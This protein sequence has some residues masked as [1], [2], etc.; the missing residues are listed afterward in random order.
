MNRY[1]YI[2]V[3]AVLLALWS[4]KSRKVIVEEVVP[5]PAVED[6][7]KPT[8]SPSWRPPVGD[9]I[10]QEMRAV[11]L[12]TA[13]GLD[14]P[15]AKADTPNGI[16]R[17]KE[18]L[19]RILDRL[20]SDG[21]NTIFYQARLSGSTTYR[22]DREPFARIFTASGEAPDYDPLAYATEACHSR[23]LSIHAWLV[24]YPLSSSSKRPHPLLVRHKDWLISHKGGWHLD[25][26]KPEVRTYIASI[27]KDI[28]Q[29]YR[30]DGIHFDY[31][32]YP[33][34]A[35][36]FRDDAS[37]LRY[38]PQGL[39][40]SQW[41]RNNLTE[42]LREVN[43]VVRQI[44]PSI[45]IS[46]APLGKLSMIPNLGRPHGWTALESVHQD[47]ETWAE[48]HI[49]D[50]VAPMMYYKDL[51][52]EP[53]LIEWVQRVG[54]Y[55]PVVPG[56]APYRI[57]E[58]GWD[59]TVISNQIALAR[60]HRASGVSM[61]REKNIGPSVPRL[62]TL[63]QRAFRATVLPIEFKPYRTD[64]PRLSAPVLTDLKLDG[65]MLTLKW[66]AGT[67]KRPLSYRVWA[68]VTHADGRQEGLLL[69]EGL[70]HT[71]CTLRITEFPSE[72]CIEFGVEALDEWNRATPCVAPI[73]YNL[74]N[75]RLMGQ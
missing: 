67:G 73:E 58:D 21:Y 9:S 25:P 5:T 49:V 16:R 54:K 1:I 7:K 31:F 64:V 12:T 60:Q 62:R 41:R 75:Y 29:R 14:W 8:I 11:W 6:P 53:F 47:V 50:F 42:Q 19:D 43:E 71:Q 20:K 33:E 38:N 4:C 24:T 45:Q 74:A 36:K 51:L 70:K 18:E 37:F 32:R 63:I 30:V 23:G 65:E 26:G 34:E 56:L 39:S 2:G 22:S 27:A 13:Y 61:F 59:P 68:K 48:Q 46:V 72:D 3:I 44:R 69:A 52:Y 57:Q 10:R 40:R 66:R 55:I 15:S 17:Q 28:V 35:D